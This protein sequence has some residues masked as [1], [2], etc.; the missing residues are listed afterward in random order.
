M[1]VKNNLFHF[2]MNGKN[3]PSLRRADLR[4]HFSFGDASVSAQR[5][6]RKAAQTGVFVGNTSNT[7]AYKLWVAGTMYVKPEWF[8]EVMNDTIEVFADRE[9][10]ESIANQVKTLTG[11]MG[12]EPTNPMHPMGQ[13]DF[14]TARIAGNDCRAVLFS[15]RGTKYDCAEGR[16]SIA[17]ALRDIMG[18]HWPPR[19]AK[20]MTDLMGRT[21]A[22]TL[23]FAT[24][25]SRPFRGASIDI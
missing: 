1:Y 6:Y 2:Q 23:E 7:E 18:V 14:I 25:T 5:Q 4:L 21:V 19:H 12:L 20:A 15:T 24:D 13:Y 9:K 16:T 22:L 3:A 17:T 10:I 11:I 8:V